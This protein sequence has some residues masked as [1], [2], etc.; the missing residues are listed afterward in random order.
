MCGFV[1]IIGRNELNEERISPIRKMAQAIAHR[2]PDDVSI[3]Q[4]HRV[5]MGFCRLGIIDLS[6]RSNQPMVDEKMERCVFVV[7]LPS[8]LEKGLSF[9]K[10]W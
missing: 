5:V 1:G 6:H 3:V 8:N 10:M 4:D 9:V 2:G 7:D